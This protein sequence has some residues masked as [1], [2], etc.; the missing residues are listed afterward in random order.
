MKSRHLTGPGRAGS[1]YWINSPL[2]GIK[3]AAGISKG[4]R[5]RDLTRLGW[6]PAL[7]TCVFIFAVAQFHRV[8]QW[9]MI[10]SQHTQHHLLMLSITPVLFLLWSQNVCCEKGLLNLASSTEL[11]NQFWYPFFCSLESVNISS[12][13]HWGQLL[14]LNWNHIVSPSC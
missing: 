14:F 2:S 3:L 6:L 1:T 8:S 4:K 5:I 11:P 9:A 10:V 7:Q 12:R 13:G